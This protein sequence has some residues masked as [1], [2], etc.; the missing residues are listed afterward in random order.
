[1]T[2]RLSLALRLCLGALLT[3]FLVAP[4]QAQETKAKAKAK[5]PAAKL[6]R[7]EGNI[8]MIDKATKTV[9]V[10]V[11]GKTEQKQVLYADTTSFTFRNKPGTVADL[12]DGRHVICLGDFN[13][14][15]QLVAK[16]IDVRDEK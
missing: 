12:K 4:A 3:L 5:A 11:R 10:Q 16:R 1:M 14:K 2:R 9:T 15:L 6:A 7:V 13:D 8:H